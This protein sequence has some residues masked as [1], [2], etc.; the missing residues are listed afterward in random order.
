M[1]VQE[2]FHNSVTL[3]AAAAGN[4]AAGD[5]ISNDADNTEGVALTF[6]NVARQQ[7]RGGYIDRACVT[8]STDTV[9]GRIRLWLFHTNP[10]ASELDDNAAFS[11]AVANRL[12]LGYID[13]PALADNG[14]LG[15]AQA[16][17]LAFPFVCASI[18]RDLYGVPQFLDAETN[19][20]A[21]MTLTFDLHGC[22]D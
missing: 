20:A 21:G 17:A 22:L 14:A 7:G 3:T 5:V 10:T 2:A 11:L 13:F 8:C 19:E 9:V 1:P 12:A 6:S 15:F 16:E 18:T 4:Y